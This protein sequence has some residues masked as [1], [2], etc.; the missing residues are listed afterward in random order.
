[1]EY[2]A[3][4]L[5]SPRPWSPVTLILIFILHTDI[6]APDYMMTEDS[7]ATQYNFLT[8]AGTAA[9]FHRIPKSVLFFADRI[10]DYIT[11]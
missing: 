6:K 8:A 10:Y 3:L 1:M 5:P 4:R 2:P 9:D 11:F 7:I